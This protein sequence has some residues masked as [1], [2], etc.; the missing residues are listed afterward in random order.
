MVVGVASSVV[1][2]ELLSVAV[3]VGEDVAVSTV[4][5]AMGRYKDPV[6]VGVV[7]SEELKISVLLRVEMPVARNKDPVVVFDVFVIIPASRLA[8]NELSFD[9]MSEYA[10]AVS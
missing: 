1:L 10:L 9:C 4:G 2:S 6:V 8:L 7:S 3:R 5:I